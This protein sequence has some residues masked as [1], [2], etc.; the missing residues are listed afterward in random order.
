MEIALGKNLPDA[1][2]DATSPQQGDADVILNEFLKRARQTAFVR[3]FS[4]TTVRELTDALII[5]TVQAIVPDLDTSLATVIL[6]D[7]VSLPVQKQGSEMRKE[8][9][10]E[11]FHRLNEP[12]QNA[13][14]INLDAYFTPNSTDVF[15]LSYS[16]Y[17]HSA[18]PPKALKLT[19][20][21]VLITYH[22]NT[23]RWDPFQMAGGQTYR[24]VGNFEKSRLLWSTPKS[25]ASPFTS[26]MLLSAESVRTADQIVA[27]VRRVAAI[28][29]MHGRTVEE[30]E[31]FG[32]PKTG[33]Y[34]LLAIDFNAPTLDL[35]AKLQAYVDFRE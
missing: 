13:A 7:I 9:A 14:A 33:V 2:P 32:I 12:L 10:L 11:A 24:L 15:T 28:C 21:G 26:K 16:N 6:V 30:L 27:A 34:Q 4:P 35:L 18:E 23:C 25:I 5:N 17:G 22:E 3:L 20:N 8:S 19:V 29:K 1:I 31:H